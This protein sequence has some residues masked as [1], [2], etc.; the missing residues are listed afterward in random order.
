MKNNHK[1]EANRKKWNEIARVHYESYGIDRLRKKET[2]LTQLELRELGN[3]KGKDILHLQCHIGTDTL[4][5]ELAGANVVGVDFSEESLAYANKLKDEL[6]FTSEFYLGNVLDLEEVIDRKFD[7]VYT[8][9]GVLGWISDI[10]KWA[11]TVATFLKQ[12]GIF[13][14]YEFH[15]FAYVFDDDNKDELKPKYPYFLKDPIHFTEESCD[16][17]DPEYTSTSESYEWMWSI[18]DIISA[19]IA[20]GIQ[21]QRFNEYD[22]T[23]SKMFPFLEHADNGFWK[24]PEGMDYI[25]LMFSLKGSKTRQGLTGPGG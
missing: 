17:A 5:L 14:I 20:E 9:K 18:S 15:P 13:Y 23:V 11:K 12:G 2:M 8:G 16:Y 6:Q 22:T 10:K 19:L 7:I 3:I 24:L 25:P 21:I 1:E 4:S